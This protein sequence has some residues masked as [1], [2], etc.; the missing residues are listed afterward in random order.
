MI[1]FKTSDNP[2]RDKAVKSAAQNTPQ[3]KQRPPRKS[4]KS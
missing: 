2:Y 3:R 1:E 4:R